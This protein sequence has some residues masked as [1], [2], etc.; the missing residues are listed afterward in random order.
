MVSLKIDS[1]LAMKVLLSIF[2]EFF[3][4]PYKLIHEMIT[5]SSSPSDSDDQCKSGNTEPILQSL[6]NLVDLVE[7]SKTGGT[8][9]EI[10]L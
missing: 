7:K 4:C 1:I 6:T 9:G 2:S 5:E 3:C 10:E 8:A